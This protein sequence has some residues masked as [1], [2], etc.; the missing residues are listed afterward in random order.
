LGPIEKKDSPEISDKWF[1]LVFSYIVSSRNVSKKRLSLAAQKTRGHVLS[2]L[3]CFQW[4]LADL[5]D[6]LFSCRVGKLFG[7]Q[8][9]F[10]EEEEARGKKQRTQSLRQLTI[11]LAVL[12]SGGRLF[13]GSMNVK[14]VGGTAFFLHSKETDNIARV[15]NQGPL[16]SHISLISLLLDVFFFPSEW[17][18]ISSGRRVWGEKNFLGGYLIFQRVGECS[19]VRGSRTLVHEEL[20]GIYDCLLTRKVKEKRFGG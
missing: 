9:V 4:P 5:A 15:K 6:K 10:R 11:A 2:T 8:S 18:E 19:L 14:K 16:Q 17:N 12:G 3:H 20:R 13:A 1:Y 7:R